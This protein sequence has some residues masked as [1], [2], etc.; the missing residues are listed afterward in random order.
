MITSPTLSP[1]LPLPF[2]S[3]WPHR[4]CTIQLI[5]RYPNARHIL[6]GSPLP[7]RFIQWINLPNRKKG[8]R[9][10]TTNGTSSK[11]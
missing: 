2:H 6:C 1:R 7:L 10:W 3:R 9:C 4:Y 8:L 5:T 11:P